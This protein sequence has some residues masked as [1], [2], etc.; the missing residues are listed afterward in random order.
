MLHAALDAVLGEPWQPH[1]NTSHY[2]GDWSGIALRSTPGSWGLF[3][4]PGSS[5]AAFLDSPLLEKALG[6]RAVL[7]ELKCPLKSVRLLR[8]KAGSVIR[9]HTDGDLGL[10]LKEVRLHVPVTTNPQLEFYVQNERIQMREGECWYLELNR[11]HRVQ[12]LGSTSRVH[13][14]ID[15]V[16]NEWLQG[17]LEAADQDPSAR[18]S[19]V[20]SSGEALEKFREVVLGDLPLQSQLQSFVSPPEFIAG[21]LRLGESRGFLFREEDVRAGLASARRAWAERDVGLTTLET[22]R[23][24]GPVTCLS[25]TALKEG[26]AGWVPARVVWEEDRPLVEWCNAGDLRFTD[27]F[28][29]QTLA[30]ALT[31]PFSLFFRQRTPMDALGDLAEADPGIYPSGFIFHMSRCGSTLVSQML[32]AV[33]GAVAVSEPAP[34]DP[35]VRAHHEHPS[36]PEETRVAWIRWMVSALGR[37]RGASGSSFFLKFDSWHIAEFETIRR[38][39]PDVPWIFLY[40][41]PVE[42]MVSQAREPGRFTLP[43]YLPAALLGLD[44]G[45]VMKMPRLEYCARILARFLHQAAGCAAR[46][47]GDLVDYRELPEAVFARIAPLFGVPLSETNVRKMRTASRF[48]SKSPQ[49]EFEPDTERKQKSASALL[50]EATHKWLAGPFEELLSQKAFSTRSDS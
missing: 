45:Q 20:A 5:P 30:Q 22:R 9:E 47:N 49:F 17:L 26:L 23:P 46:H 19:R 34:L 7:A 50:R 11:P 12:N 31:R 15:C 27:P 35:L 18:P 33:P 40:R 28:Y 36:I 8:L 39:F 44:S 1:F 42:V 38:A 24:A 43:G 25:N 6:F 2:D 21:M 16:L 41:D 29:E 10:D 48:D 13:L 37:T 32:A 14:V 4:N 3:A